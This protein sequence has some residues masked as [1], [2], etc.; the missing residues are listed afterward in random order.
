MSISMLESPV[1]GGLVVVSLVI[2]G[3]SAGLSDAGVQV[4]VP[5]D[6]G[7]AIADVSTSNF[8]FT[9]TQS[10]PVEDV[11]LQLAMEHT[12]ITDLTVTLISPSDQGN[13]SVSVELFRYLAPNN[14]DAE[15]RDAVFDDDS[16]PFQQGRIGAPGNL[17]PPY[18]YVYQP[19][20]E[21]LSAFDGIEAKGTWT[22][23]ITDDEAGD[24]GQLYAPGQSAPWGTTVGTK[25][26]LTI[27]EPAGVSLLVAGACALLRRRRGA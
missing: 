26:I 10:G 24:T 12:Y 9:M 20:I 16:V 4:E 18:Q 15:F 25:L 3:L 13:P 14:E 27:P 8:T 6:L 1:R 22:L 5:V 23:V 19:Q 7:G 21:D 2:V 11:N 17:E